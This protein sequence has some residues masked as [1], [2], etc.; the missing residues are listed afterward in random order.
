MTVSASPVFEHKILWS[1]FVRLGYSRQ[2]GGQRVRFI[3]AGGAG[4][5]LRK[6]DFAGFAV[7]WSGP[8]DSSLRNQFTTEAYYRLQLTHNVQVTP[9]FQFTIHPSRTTE[10]DTL[11]VVSVLRVRFSL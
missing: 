3:A 10:T 1:P 4:I 7:S 6:S 11:W 8:P 9:G 2:D 5:V